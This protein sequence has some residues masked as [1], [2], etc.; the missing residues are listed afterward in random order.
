M[1]LADFCNPHFKDEH[2]SHAWLPTLR[3]PEGW[4]I[5]AARTRFARRLPQPEAA[6]DRLE[7]EECRSSD[8][9]VAR[10]CSVGSPRDPWA[11]ADSAANP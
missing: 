3:T 10:R 4:A 2:P 11:K 9:L 5:H 8:A 1:R 6:I 7:R